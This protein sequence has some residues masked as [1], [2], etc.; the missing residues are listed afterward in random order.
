MLY[1]R[2]A[3]ALP[4]ASAVVSDVI[5]AATHSE[6]KYSTFKNNA[7]AD[8]GV[9]FV[10]DFESAY[11]LRLSVDDKAGVLAKITGI[12][13]KCGISIVEISQK[14]TVKADGDRVPLIVITHK[15]NEN[16]VKSA[17][18]KINALGLGA[19]EAVIRVEQ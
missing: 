4:T 5:Y 16:A 1:G 13:G 2:G 12:F 8:S 3:G 10:S 19:V 18:A 15:T 17:V 14:S 11:Y 6:I 7:T 9:K